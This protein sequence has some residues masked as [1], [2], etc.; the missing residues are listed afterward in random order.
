MPECRHHPRKSYSSSSPRARVSTRRPARPITS[1]GK[2]MFGTPRPSPSSVALPSVV[3]SPSVDWVGHS[4]APAV[5]PAVALPP[6]PVGVGLLVPFVLLLPLVPLVVG[7]ALEVVGKTI[8][9]GFG[10]NPPP[11]DELVVGDAEPLA[12]VVEVGSDDVVMLPPPP[13]PAPA[14]APTHVSPAPGSEVVG[15]ADE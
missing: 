6:P 8:V 12:F 4:L 7:D 3:S 9:I 1:I 5:P 13:P 10:G 2:P 15:A 14:P 11:D